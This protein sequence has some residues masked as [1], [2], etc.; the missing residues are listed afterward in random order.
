MNDLPELSA[1]VQEATVTELE[2]RKVEVQSE[3]VHKKFVP[4]ANAMKIAEYLDIN[5]AALQVRSHPNSDD[6][7]SSA[8]AMTNGTS[9]NN[10]LPIPR[11]K[12]LQKVAAQRKVAVS[13][14]TD[15]TK[16]VANKIATLDPAKSLQI[17]EQIHP[18]FKELNM[19]EKQKNLKQQTR[20]H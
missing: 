7:S 14:I 5:C 15:N 13:Q 11:I 8:G 16:A 9:E 19:Q 17:T 1:E 3:A 10:F 4:Y 18:L 2:E 6:L 20:L 12:S